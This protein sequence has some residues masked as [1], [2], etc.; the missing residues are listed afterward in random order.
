MSRTLLFSALGLT[1]LGTQLATAQSIGGADA[2]PMNT[3][4]R[5]A[6]AGESG[7]SQSGATRVVI[8]SDDD[9]NIG[10]AGAFP[11]NTM[12]RIKAAELDVTRRRWSSNSAPVTVGR[13]ATPAVAPRADAWRYRWYQNRW[14]YYG[15]DDQWQY[16]S[17]NRWHKFAGPTAASKQP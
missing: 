15:S 17:A 6:V 4:D 10:R 9:D 8:T 3:L 2:Y 5:I 13:E 11:M 7:G 12:D 1:L 14:W 16:W